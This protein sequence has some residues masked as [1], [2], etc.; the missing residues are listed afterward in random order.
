M[1][2]STVRGCSIVGRLVGPV[3][4]ALTVLALP[5]TAADFE[6]SLGVGI[7]GAPTYD[8]VSLAGDLTLGVHATSGVSVG[9]E[10]F[11]HDGGVSRVSNNFNL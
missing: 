5:A 4:L 1:K 11:I 10:A 3:I 6:G 9:I 2:T 8:S 7:A